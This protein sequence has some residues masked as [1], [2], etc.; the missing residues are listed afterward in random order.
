MRADPSKRHAPAHL[1]HI[2][3]LGLSSHVVKET[4]LNE[5]AFWIL[6]TLSTGRN[7]G[8]AIIR[9]SE[10]LSQ[11]RVRL[12]ATTLYSVLDR[13]VHDG[14]LQSAGDEVVDGR[15]R[16]YFALTDSGEQRLRVEIDRL[17]A[18]ALAARQQIS[19]R[20]SVAIGGIA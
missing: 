4:E 8:Y 20:A 3:I 5:P 13:L 7:H 9:A 18:N 1:G 19:A 2:P 12:K 17:E 16:R 15:L 14:C 11:G 6:T 10:E